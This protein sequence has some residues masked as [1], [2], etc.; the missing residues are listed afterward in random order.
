MTMIMDHEKTN[1]KM[2]CLQLAGRG[3]ESKTPEQV[4]EAAKAFYDFA[5]TEV[6]LKKV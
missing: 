4:L 1:A 6:E 3:E 2:A 5:Y